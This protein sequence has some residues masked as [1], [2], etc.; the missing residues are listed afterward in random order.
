M[1][2]LKHFRLFKSKLDELFEQ[3]EESAI[4]SNMQMEGYTDFEI[5]IALLNLR[6]LKERNSVQSTGNDV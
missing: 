2:I 1:G 3:L 5:S 4:I 6:K